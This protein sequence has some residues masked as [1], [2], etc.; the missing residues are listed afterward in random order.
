MVNKAAEDVRVVMVGVGAAG[1][2]CMH[3]MRDMGITNI[4]GCDAGALYVGRE[5]QMDE[6]KKAFA[7]VTNPERKAH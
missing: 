3:M 6:A 4:I 7:A 5:E 2:A 1:T